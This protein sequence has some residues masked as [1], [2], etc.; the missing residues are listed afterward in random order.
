MD[1]VVIGSGISGARIAWGLLGDEDGDVKGEK[2]RV[3]M[4]EARQTCSGASGRNGIVISS[5]YLPLIFYPSP[6]PKDE[7]KNQDTD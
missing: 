3:V 4:L 1:T 6:N 5:P 7:Q 2:R